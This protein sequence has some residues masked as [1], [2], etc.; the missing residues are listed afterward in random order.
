MAPAEAAASR[1]RP[2]AASAPRRRGRLL[3]AARSAV[4]H[5]RTMSVGH[6]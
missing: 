2:R 1:L 5:P 6:R 4:P 3:Q